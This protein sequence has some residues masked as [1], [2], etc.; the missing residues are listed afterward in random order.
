MKMF[1]LKSFIITALMFIAVFTGMELANNGIHKMKGYDDPNFQN[2]V[3]INERDATILGNKISS[4][5]L[6]AKKKKL[7]EISAYNFFSNMGKKLS[8]SLTNASEK[9]IKKIAD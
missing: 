1:M 9:L 7:E 3:S 8:D 2:A 6:E 4:H 5:D